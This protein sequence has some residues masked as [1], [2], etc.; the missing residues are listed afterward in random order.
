[1]SSSGSLPK[2]ELGPKLESGFDRL[3]QAMQEPCGPGQLTLDTTLDARNRISSIGG[4][5]GDRCERRGVAALSLHDYYETAHERFSAPD[6]GRNR[7]NL[8][9]ILKWRTCRRNRPSSAR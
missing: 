2:L 3:R 7:R 5:A 1:M 4:A 8:W 6:R 9:S